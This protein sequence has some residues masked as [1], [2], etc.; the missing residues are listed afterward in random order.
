MQEVSF[1]S[2]KGYLSHAKRQAFAR[3]K[4]AFLNALNIKMLLSNVQTVY[5]Y[6]FP[7]LFRKAGYHVTFLTNQYLPAGKGGR[8]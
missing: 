2:V 3:Q 6:S 8:V 4:D 1:R 5:K 7:E